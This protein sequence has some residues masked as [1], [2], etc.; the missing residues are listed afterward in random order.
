MTRADFLTKPD[1]EMTP[2]D[3]RLVDE[4]RT[5]ARWAQQARLGVTGAIWC[6]E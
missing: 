3:W 2:L 1:A 6:R 4:V 5:Y